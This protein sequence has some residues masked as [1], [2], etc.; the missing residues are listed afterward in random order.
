MITQLAVK[1]VVRALPA[2]VLGGC[3]GLAVYLL[4]RAGGAYLFTLVGAALGAAAALTA[5]FYRRT[6]RLTEMT[7][8]VPQLSGF[9]FMVNDDTKQVSWQL[10][11]E[12]VTRT[13]TQRLGDD[14]GLIREALTSLYGLFATTRTI[15]SAARPTPHGSGI[16]VEYLAVNLLNRELRPFLSKWHPRLTAFEN[17]HPELPESAWPD[18]AE[19][20]GELARIQANTR[21]YALGFAELAGVRDPELML[22]DLRGAGSVPGPSSADPSSPSSPPDPPDASSPS[23]TPA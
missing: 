20:R 13:S 23:S 19:C 3:G 10:F 17:A 22:G 18:A 14:E 21:V 2:A 7:I 8:T 1:R 5:D 12:T 15:L 6:A 16:T 9:T 11:V 4:N